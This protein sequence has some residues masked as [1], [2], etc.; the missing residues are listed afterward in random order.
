MSDYLK[1]AG[2]QE[3]SF[4]LGV[5]GPY[6]APALIA[7]TTINIDDTDADNLKDAVDDAKDILHLGGTKTILCAAGTYN[8]PNLRYL[9][10]RYGSGLVIEGDTRDT[11]GVGFINGGY[12]EDGF[13]GSGSGTYAFSLSGDTLTVTGTGSNPDFS[14][15]VSGDTVV[16]YDPDR[17]RTLL[18][19]DSTST[20]T[21]TFTTTPDSDIED[22]GAAIA[23]RAN[24]FITGIV[25]AGA[26]SLGYVQF[27]GFTFDSTVLHHES[28][29]SYRPGYDYGADS[30][31]YVVFR[32]CVT[33]DGSSVVGT[34]PQKLVWWESCWAHGGISG[35]GVGRQSPRGSL[36]LLDSVTCIGLDESDGFEIRDSP[37]VRLV[38][39]TLGVGSNSSSPQIVNLYG[40]ELSAI[41]CQFYVLSSSSAV[42]I[43]VTGG[44]DEVGPAFLH[45]N[46]CLIENLY[47][48]AAGTGVRVADGALCKSKNT[49][50]K[51]FSTGRTAVELGRIKAL[52]GDTFTSC[53]TDESPTAGSGFNG[54]Y[55]IIE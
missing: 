3:D 48:S 11:I 1:I 46:G 9:Y 34:L 54:S 8:A 15:L 4:R 39:T 25:Y 40:G 52:G 7:N 30:L 29:A 23:P 53:T 10:G 51:N 37:T 6:A 27:R 43:N 16:F 18:T 45:L 13:N 19:V 32:Q 36:L 31:G 24:R 38:N 50:Y 17:N 21:I 22:T 26:G 20:N 33:D 35:H 44:G 55:G 42:A 12:R 47:S 2:T 41:D 14:E 28:T 5:S 49:E